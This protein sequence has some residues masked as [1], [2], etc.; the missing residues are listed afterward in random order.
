MVMELAWRLGADLDAP[1]M[2]ERY[3]RA[4]RESGR[5]IAL[6]QLAYN[7]EDLRG[8][9]A[10]GSEVWV[11]YGAELLSRFVAP[12]DEGRSGVVWDRTRGAYDDA[13]ARLD[14]GLGRTAGV[15]AVRHRR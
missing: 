1:G 12:D 14:S 10:A 2:L 5:S 9:S 8:W 13:L 15:D 4:A 11:P 6:W 3:E 7:E